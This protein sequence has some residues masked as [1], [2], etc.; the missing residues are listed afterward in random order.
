MLGGSLADALGAAG[1][2]IAVAGR[3][4]ERGEARAESIRSAGGTAGFFEADALLARQ[5]RGMREAVTK[6][7]GVDILNQRSRGHRPEGNGD[8]GSQI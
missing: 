7:W 3:S 5:H 4:R 8:G 1:A 6:E 2:K